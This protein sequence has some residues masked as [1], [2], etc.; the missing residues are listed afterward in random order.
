VDRAELQIVLTEQPQ[1][2][3]GQAP[4]PTNQQTFTLNPPR[5]NPTMLAIQQRAVEMEYESLFGPRQRPPTPRTERPQQTVGEA[6]LGTLTGAGAAG[7]GSTLT[8]FAKAIGPVGI[9][10]IAA[11]GGLFLLNRRVNQLADTYGQYN[12]QIAL[13]QAQAQVRGTLGDIRRADESAP[14]FARY[15]EAQS[16][17]EQE[18]KDVE[19]NLLN[20]LLPLA[21]TAVDSLT[22]LLA[23]VKPITE[24][25]AFLS[26]TAD[27]LSGLTDFVRDIR[28]L[29]RRQTENT[30][31]QFDTRQLF[32]VPEL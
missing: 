32:A 4:S 11:A 31:N 3:V 18:W 21:T 10:A 25:L 1:S 2:T 23:I 26:K 27:E 20:A 13:A 19:T 5:F 29:F 17:L 9:A 15:I 7:L 24:G 16:H 14:N 6:A 30:E 22:I 28:N 8:A 12:A